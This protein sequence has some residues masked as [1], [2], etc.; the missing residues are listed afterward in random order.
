[1]ENQPTLQILATEQFKEIE[2]EKELTLRYAI[3]NF[4]RLVSFTDSIES[5]RLI[6]GSITEGYRIMRY[7]VRQNNKIRY[8]HLFLYKSVA[9]HFLEK[10]SDRHN[11][12]LHLDHNLSN[13]HYSNLRWATKQEMV[14]HHQTSPKV[15]RAKKI[16]TQRLL[17]YVKK[18]DGRKLNTTKVMTIKKLLA[19]P[20]RTTRLK[21]IA[22]RFNIS[23]MQLYR[24]KTGQNWGHVKIN[25]YK[26]PSKI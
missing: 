12:V 26:T 5:G 17:H 10:Q 23:Q 21:I 6:K 9:E 8:K 7:R 24:I 2:L 14:A 11:H 13:D 3:S 25:E 20:N 15:I 22:R 18:M 4:G 19:K 1:M 16:S